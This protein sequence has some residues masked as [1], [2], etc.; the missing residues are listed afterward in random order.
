MGP[1]SLATVAGATTRDG[2]VLAQI[3]ADALGE[4]ADSFC[5]IGR[6]SYAKLR[7]I[8]LYHEFAR[9]LFL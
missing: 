4:D 9:R 6:K 3:P 5:G 2:Q 1:D 7:G 8:G